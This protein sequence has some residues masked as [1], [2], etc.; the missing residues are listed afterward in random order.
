ML[1]LHDRHFEKH[2][3]S[4]QVFE[5]ISILD[6]GPIC[7]GLQLWSLFLNKLFLL[8]FI[9]ASTSSVVIFPS[10]TTAGTVSLLVCIHVASFQFLCYYKMII[11]TQHWWELC[12]FFFF[13]F[14]SALQKSTVSQ[15]TQ[16]ISRIPEVNFCNILPCDKV[17]CCPIYQPNFKYLIYE[18]TDAEDKRK[19]KC[20]FLLFVIWIKTLWRVWRKEQGSLKVVRFVR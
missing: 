1:S 17:Y 7:F 11:D 13:L 15:S 10:T 9:S 5:L 16:P 18:K 8:F 2:P 20:E 14:S 19:L 6:C 12:L 3:I 4:R